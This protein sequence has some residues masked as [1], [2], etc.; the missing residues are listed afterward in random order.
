MSHPRTDRHLLLSP[1]DV[2]RVSVLHSSFMDYLVKLSAERYAVLARW[3]DFTA[4]VGCRE[5]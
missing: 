4:A 3:P 1:Q 5:V 2:A